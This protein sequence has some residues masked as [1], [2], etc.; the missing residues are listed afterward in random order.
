MLGYPDLLTFVINFDEFGWV[1]KSLPARSYIH[2]NQLVLARKPLRAR[3]SV[4]VGCTSSGIKFTPLVIG[5]SQ[6]PRCFPRGEELPVMYCGQPSAWMTAELFQEYFIEVIIKQIET[7]FPNRRV[8]L[9]LDQAIC[10]PEI[11]WEFL[12]ISVLNF[13]LPT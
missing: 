10:H 8:V 12:L 5:V 4:L 9:T 3:L 11:I 7:M 1:M 2:N 6:R 13:Y